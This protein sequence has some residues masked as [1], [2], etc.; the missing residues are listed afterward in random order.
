MAKV[1]LGRVVGKSTYEIWQEQGNTGTEQ[2]FL[3][4]LKGKDGVNGVNGEDGKDGY[5]PIKG[6]DYFDGKDGVDGAKGE[7][8]PQGDQGIQGVAGKDGTNGSNGQDGFSPVVTVTQTETGATIS[9]TDKNGN[10]T[11]DILN[12]KEGKDGKNYNIEIVENVSTT[13]EIQANKFYKFGEV[14]ELNISLALPTDT[15]ILNEYMFEFISGNT[16]TTLTLP[17]EIKWLEIPSI[18]T[19]KIYQCS[20]VNN[21]GILVGV[22]N[23]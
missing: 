5:T 19:K 6:V 10:T 17:D 3:E 9:I 11:V 16:A 23:V 1:N 2:E 12:G 20:I 13:Q 8:G 4:S 18:E 7:Q 21:I 14:T 22:A 15:T